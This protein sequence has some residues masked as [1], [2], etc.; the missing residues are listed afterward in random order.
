M[1]IEESQHKRSGVC[2]LKVTVPAGPAL[3]LRP[4]SFARL[5]RAKIGIVLKYMS[6]LNAA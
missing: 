4:C 1:D 6:Y 5:H 2:L 3:R